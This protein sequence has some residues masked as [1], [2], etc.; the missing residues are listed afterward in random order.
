[1]LVAVHAQ[2]APAVTLKLF[3]P[4]A[5]ATVALVTG[6]LTEHPLPCVI[7]KALPAT[8][9]TAVRLTPVFGCAL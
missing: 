8:V 9:T 6:K 5:A 1:L 4:P 3:V 2:P 7:V